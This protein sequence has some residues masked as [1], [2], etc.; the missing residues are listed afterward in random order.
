MKLNFLNTSFLVSI[1][2]A[3]SL[4]ANPVLAAEKKDKASRRAQQMVQQ[5][6]QEKAHYS[7]SKNK[8]GASPC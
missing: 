3:T 2:L 6:Q 8:R 5:I 7:L 1:L 4:L